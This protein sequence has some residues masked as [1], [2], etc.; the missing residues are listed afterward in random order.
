MNNEA[1]EIP[2]INTYDDLNPTLRS[3]NSLYEIQFY[4]TKESLLDVESYKRFLDNAISR[5]RHSKTYKNFKG[6]LIGLGLDKCQYLGNIN[7]EM[8]T[9]EMHHVITIYDI[10]L[11]ICE[12]ILNTVN[13]I[14]T[15]DLVQLLKEE[16]K[17]YNVPIVMLS[18]TPHQLY[19][20]DPEF[21]ISP[22]MVFGRWD[23]LLEKYKYGITQDIAFKLLL[24]I[25]KALE[26]DN[27]NDN[28][29]LDLREKIKDWSVNNN[30]Y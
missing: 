11:I 29:L 1:N 19:H 13:R 17:A 24:Y 16:H 21:F 7:T 26:D 15:F 20:S 2:G 8:A 9:I 4:Q 22:K 18:L 6:H 27:S 3:P 10:A 5:F 23:V 28:G 14:S 12:H 25:K 30:V